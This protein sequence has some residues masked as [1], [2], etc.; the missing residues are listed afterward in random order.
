MSCETL[1]V[2]LW[3][4]D[5]YKRIVFDMRLISLLPWLL[6]SIHYKLDH[7]IIQSQFGVAKGF[8]KSQYTPEKTGLFLCFPLISESKIPCVFPVISLC[9]FSFHCVLFP[10]TTFSC[11][12]IACSLIAIHYKLDHQS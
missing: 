3:I 2:C 6:I 1:N 7:K 10:L 5:F 4:G 11:F 12:F 9:N 8:N